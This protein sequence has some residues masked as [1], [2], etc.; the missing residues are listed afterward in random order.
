LRSNIFNDTKKTS[1]KEF[2][3]GVLLKL[4]KPLK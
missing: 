2:D 3:I 4:H 1:I